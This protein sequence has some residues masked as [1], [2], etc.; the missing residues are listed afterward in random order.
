VSIPAHF[1][2]AEDVA[3]LT[4]APKR[5]PPRNGW[6][7]SA[8]GTRSVS[9]DDSRALADSAW[10]ITSRIAA[11]L[12]LYTGLGWLLSLWIGHQALLMASGAMIGLTLSYVLIFGG[13]AKE[14]KRYMDLT[15]GKS[16]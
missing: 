16:S 11:G 4:T 1:E 2:G 12:I 14:N 9:L 6:Y 7:G 15:N 8:A 3:K 13:L 10:T 5:F